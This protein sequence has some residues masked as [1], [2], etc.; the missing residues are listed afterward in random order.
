MIRSQSDYPKGVSID[1][2]GVVKNLGPA[3]V[4]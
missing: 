4:M 2:G 1:G 3:S